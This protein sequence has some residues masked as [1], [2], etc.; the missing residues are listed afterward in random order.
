MTYQLRL[1]Q[2]VR[3]LGI[4]AKVVGFHEITGDPI[5]CLL[6]NDGGRWLADAAK[7]EPVG[8]ET[9]ETLRHKDGL[10]NPGQTGV[11]SGKEPNVNYRELSGGF[12]PSFCC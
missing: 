9:A 8:D 11:H 2:T 3:N 7:C 4:L 10:V 6:W 5:L 1:N 12:F